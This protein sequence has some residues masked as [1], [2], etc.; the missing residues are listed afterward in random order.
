MGIV[1]QATATFIGTA[2]CGWMAVF[3]AAAQAPYPSAPIRLIVPNPPGGL[4]DVLAR[5]VSD[6]L[7][8][9]LGQPIVI[10]NRPGANAGIGA[11]AVTASKPDGY[12]FLVSDSAVINVSPLLNNELP[13]NPKELMPVTLIGRAPLYLGA[14]S[15][16]TASTL[17]D[18]IEQAKAN[19]GKINYGSIGVGSFHHLTMEAI[20]A[21]FGIK[22]NHIPYKGSGESVTA[23]RAGQIQ[24]VFASY[25]GILPAVKSQ[26]ARLIVS[27]GLQRSKQA[28]DIPAIAETIPGFD[29]TVSQSLYARTGTPVALAERIAVAMAQVTSDPEIVERFSVLGV[30]AAS[31]GPAELERILKGEGERVLKVV[32]AADLKPN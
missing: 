1:G 20:Q 15:A 9:R 12:T 24:L 2:A 30:E 19:P 32:K 13:F 18:V 17:K 10:E 8:E 27:N 29:L 16:F 28:P 26:Q 31:A 14:H 23:L 22:L 6:K 11:A 7:R 21:E 5:I 4:P 25:A 3:P